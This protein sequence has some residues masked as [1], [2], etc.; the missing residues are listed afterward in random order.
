MISDALGRNTKV[1]GVGKHNKA[2]IK[3]EDIK[4]LEQIGDGMFGLVYKA[5]WIDNVVAIKEFKDI[6]FDHDDYIN[7]FEIEAARLRKK[8]LFSEILAVSTIEYHPNII[9]IFGF[10]IKKPQN[11]LFIVMSYME[12][13]NVEN[14]IYLEN[15]Q[16]RN[17]NPNN[18]KD[19]SETKSNAQNKNTNTNTS[20]I[21]NL[22]EKLIILHKACNGLKY[23]HNKC[24]IV[25]RDIAARN[26]L[27]GKLNKSENYQITKNTEIRITDFGLSR[28]VPLTKNTKNGKN[29]KN[30]DESK[31]NDVKN[32]HNVVDKGD[33]SMDKFGPISWMAPESITNQIY[34]VKTDVYMFA[35]TIWEILYQSKP[36][37]NMNLNNFE[38][39][40]NVVRNQLRPNI[41][42]DHKNNCNDDIN[43]SK[44][45]N[46]KMSDEMTNILQQ[47]GLLKLK[48]SERKKFKQLEK[49]MKQCWDDDST[50]RPD[51][52]QIKNKLPKFATYII[53]LN[54][55]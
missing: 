29:T 45:K 31:T 43:S 36:Y 9:E 42:P 20:N 25:H 23:L 4:V 22:N 38:I 16:K 32:K 3:F 19:E 30:S 34:S 50:L 52:D 6:T 44:D 39:A 46:N 48:K 37:K 10:T 28:K 24:G 8:S 12:S 40:T 17:C 26:I 51:F 35:I 27:I 2:E 33:Y 13:G 1:P 55:K 15:R 53:S 49:L 54:S 47:V 18:C 11:S 14:W 21:V 7:N 5:K 41:N